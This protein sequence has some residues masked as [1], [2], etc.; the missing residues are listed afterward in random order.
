MPDT[1][2]SD[3]IGTE[4]P[5]DIVQ[6][7]LAPGTAARPYSQFLH[8]QIKIVTNDDHFVIRYLIKNLVPPRHSA[9][10]SS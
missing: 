3:L 2:S 1:Q 8:W 10:Y 9:R 4:H 6:A 7:V 5:K